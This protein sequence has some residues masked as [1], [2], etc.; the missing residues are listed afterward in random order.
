MLAHRSAFSVLLAVILSLFPIVGETSVAT[1]GIVS[2]YANDGS[3]WALLATDPSGNLASVSSYTTP[4]GAFK[5]TNSYA[6]MQDGPNADLNSSTFHIQHIGGSTD[7]LSLVMIGTFF[8]SPTSQNNGPILVNSQVSG[9]N[10]TGALTALTFQS[11]IDS[12]NN[13]NPASLSGGIG[14]QTPPIF[15]T[16][17]SD[18]ST[19]L[20]SLG[21]P[22]SAAQQ[23]NLTMTGDG[24]IVSL[25]GDTSL[26]PNPG[27]T[28][29]PASIALV[30][31]CA[32]AFA[33][34]GWRR[35]RIA[36]NVNATSMP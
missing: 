34:Y 20:S 31:I 16:I 5:I 13:G 15:Q 33:G 36:M 4:G 8:T 2:I 7:N 35:R 6:S 11:F 29:E 26:S 9:I 25:G 12:T 24:L 28:P 23:F 18:L 10:Q 32:S 22:Y 3:G 17:Y 1:A 19:V 27:S 21:A 14:V 30:C